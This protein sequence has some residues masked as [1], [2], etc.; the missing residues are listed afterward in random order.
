[1][2]GSIS[3]NSM[4][5]L[6]FEAVSARI[7]ECR[8]ELYKNGGS[9]QELQ[10]AAEGF[11]RLADSASVPAI[12]LMCKYKLGWC[13]ERMNDPRAAYGAY[14]QALLYANTLKDARRPFDPKW[15]SRSAYAAL[16]LLLTHRWPNAD[17]MGAAIITLARALEL[18]GG[19]AEFDAAQNE[20]NE[21]FLNR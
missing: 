19:N 20:F 14:H 21:R 2:N 13:R 3:E 12:R 9:Q 1:M 15:C 16:N 5:S 17:Q 8:L 6:S 4:I 11:E 7:A 10:A 18:P